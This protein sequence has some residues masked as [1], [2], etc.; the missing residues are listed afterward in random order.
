[1]RTLAIAA[2]ALLALTGCTI[3]SSDSDSGGGGVG[4]GGGGGS[5]GAFEYCGISGPGISA[6]AQVS[7]EEPTNQGEYCESFRWAYEEYLYGANLAVCDGF[8]DTSDS[9]YI[10]IFMSSEGGGH[11]RSSALGM[12]DAMWVKC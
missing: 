8:W 4:S 6:S 10:N 5:S 9:E 12:V 11:S 3:E 2:I 1:M 7:D